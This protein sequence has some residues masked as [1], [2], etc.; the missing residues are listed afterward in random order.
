MDPVRDWLSAAEKSF[1]ARLRNTCW[2]LSIASWVSMMVVGSSRSAFAFAVAGAAWLVPAAIFNMG[3]RFD[4][5][6]IWSKRVRI[7]LERRR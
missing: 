2:C 6:I 3:R 1:Y 7:W 5:R 4:V